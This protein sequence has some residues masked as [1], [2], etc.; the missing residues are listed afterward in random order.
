MFR[1]EPADASPD[2]TVAFA[3]KCYDANGLFHP[4]DRRFGHNRV[5]TVSGTS[6]ALSGSRVEKTERK[7]SKATVS[8]TAARLI[9]IRVR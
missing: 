5:G 1:D 9:P 3:A 4:S 8:L 6:R 7:R 2:Q